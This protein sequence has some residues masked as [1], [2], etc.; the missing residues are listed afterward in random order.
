MKFENCKYNHLDLADRFLQMAAKFMPY[1]ANEG[2][3]LDMGEP[4]VK[5]HYCGTT[6]CHGGYAALIFNAGEFYEDGAKRLAKFLGFACV[7]SLESWAH[8]NGQ[9]WGNQDGGYMFS[10]RLAFGVDMD[11]DIDLRDVVTHYLSVAK[12]LIEL[13]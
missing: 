8:Y 9:L 3:R 12:R 6:A 1:A 4:F 11:S 2:N 13:K 7:G 5:N 10:S